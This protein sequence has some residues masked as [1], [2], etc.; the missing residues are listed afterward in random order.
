MKAEIFN[1][2]R[3]LFQKPV[4]G[5]IRIYYSHGV[6][7]ILFAEIDSNSDLEIVALDISE[8]EL[9]AK[10]LRPDVLSGK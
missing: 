7:K 1:G 10:N 3:E 5:R 6:E 4:R 9:I 2:I 8:A